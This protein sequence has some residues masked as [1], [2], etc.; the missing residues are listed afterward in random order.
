MLPGEERQDFLAEEGFWE[1]NQT[2]GIHQHDMRRNRCWE[3][4]GKT[5]NGLC[6]GT[7]ARIWQVG[8]A[9]NLPAIEPM[10]S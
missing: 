7:E 9:E 6:R 10:F 4:M 3:S 1:R 2:W 8:V 5:G